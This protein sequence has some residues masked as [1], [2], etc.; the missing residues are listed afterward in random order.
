[1]LVSPSL[2]T[3]PH[4]CHK[5]TVF[6]PYS[7]KS[8]TKFSTSFFINSLLSGSNLL[9]E[10]DCRDSRTKIRAEKQLIKESLLQLYSNKFCHSMIGIVIKFNQMG[11]VM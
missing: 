5:R 7:Y 9:H 6:L 8:S 1:M 10:S 4:T 11:V 2:L 3:G